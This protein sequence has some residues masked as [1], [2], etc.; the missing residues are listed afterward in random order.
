MVSCY[1]MDVDW[2]FTLSGEGEL[3]HGCKGVL[4]LYGC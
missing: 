1:P 4:P 3:F 2:N